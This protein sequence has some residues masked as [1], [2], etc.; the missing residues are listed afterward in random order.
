MLGRIKFK[1]KK[2]N[3]KKWAKGALAVSTGGLSL[4][5]KKN[6]KNVAKG[7]LAVSTGGLSLVNKKNIKNVAKGAL[8]VSTGG[9]SLAFKKA[10]P[11]VVKPVVTKPISQNRIVHTNLVR[12][13]AQP[14]QISSKS[15]PVVRPLKTVRKSQAS[16]PIIGYNPTTK[17]VVR[18]KPNQAKGSGVNISI[19]VNSQNA[20]RPQVK[21]NKI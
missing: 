2:P 15:T 17:K 6:I 4:V 18:A 21:S 16:T 9:A 1:I 3:F 13:T 10:R 5:N 20:P 11:T 12:P 8:A 19:N 14:T 7:A